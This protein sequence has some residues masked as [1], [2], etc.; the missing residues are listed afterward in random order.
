VDQPKPLDLA[1]VRA[2]LQGAAA[3]FRAITELQPAG[4]TGDKVF[5]ATYEGGEYAFETRVVEGNRVPCVVLD[6]VQSQANRLE[7]AL[8]EGYRA[9]ALRFPVVQIDFR[10]ADQPETRDVGVVTA[11]EAPHRLADALFGASQVDEGG[12]PKPFR[13]REPTKTSSIGRRLNEASSAKATPL[14]ELCPTA[15]IFGMWDSHGP[16]GG[17]GERFQRAVVS[18]IIGLDAQAG[19]RAASRIDPVIRTARDIP[20]EKCTEGGWR[21]AEK[22]KTKLSEVGL[23]NVTPSLRDETGRQHHGGVTLRSARQIWVLSLPALRRLRFPLERGGARLEDGAVNLAARTTL[24]ALALAALSWQWRAGFDLRS[25]CLLVPP[26]DL[27]IELLSPGTVASFSLL[28][29]DAAR[30]LADAAREAREAG[31]EWREEALVVY[32]NAE[33]A[34]AVQM[35]RRM[36]ATEVSA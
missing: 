16:R 10:T 35:S 21:V 2:A 7:L 29:E 24:A 15:L 8:L 32:P 12:K 30:L 14:F 25:R 4:G 28:P 17:L 27:R 22:G 18:E 5:P 9:G 3:A 31:L 6:S 13:H 19:V 23:G 1:T 33:L 36:A 20:V 26:G 11:L 34:K